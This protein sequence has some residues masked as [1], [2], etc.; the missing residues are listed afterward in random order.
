MLV[1]D[2]HD[3]SHLAPGSGGSARNGYVDF[4]ASSSSF[5]VHRNTQKKRPCKQPYRHI[6]RTLHIDKTGAGQS[7]E[8]LMTDFWR[9]FSEDGVIPP[10][11]QMRIDKDAEDVPDAAVD[12]GTTAPVGDG[13]DA[14]VEPSAKRLRE[15]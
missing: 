5:G 8:G 14:A 4:I 10:T 15:F 12:A 11:I 2:L 7:R 13:A 1:C 3:H 6:Y 9:E